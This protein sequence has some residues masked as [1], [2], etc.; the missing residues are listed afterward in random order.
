MIEEAVP[1]AKKP[2]SPPSSKTPR[3]A[4]TAAAGVNNHTRPT[5]NKR[6]NLP[7]SGVDEKAEWRRHGQRGKVIIKRYE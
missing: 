6:A 1:P 7:S 3:N 5:K 4:S 2:V